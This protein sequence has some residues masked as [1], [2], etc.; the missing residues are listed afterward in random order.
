MDLW[1]SSVD[2]QGSKFTIHTPLSNA[3]P[4]LRAWVYACFNTVCLS[5]W[6]STQPCLNSLI[7][8]CLLHVRCAL[9]V[10]GIG[11]TCDILCWCS[12]IL[13][14]AC[15]FATAALFMHVRLQKKCKFCD[16]LT[17]DILSSSSAWFILYAGAAGVWFIL[18][19]KKLHIISNTTGLCCTW[20]PDVAVLPMG[21]SNTNPNPNP[22]H[23][24]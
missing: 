9:A 8:K 14:D 3:T 16:T 1:S 20:C 7:S 13:G 6:R 24:L 11:P 23:N 4:Q 10:C 15:R 18:T 22:Y 17:D 2:W 19:G 5:H 12:L 21:Y